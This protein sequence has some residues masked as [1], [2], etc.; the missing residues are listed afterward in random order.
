MRRRGA[1]ELLD[2]AVRAWNGYHSLPVLT[3]DGDGYVVSDTNLIF[4]YQNRVAL[5]GI[6]FHLGGGASATSSGGAAR[7]VGGQ[8]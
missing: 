2:E 8:S 5:S 6:G 7:A 3:V 4:Y 1:M